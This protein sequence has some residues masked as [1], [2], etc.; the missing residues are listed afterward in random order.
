MPREARAAADRI[1]LEPKALYVV[2]TPIGNLGDVTF[3]AAATLASVDV[4]CAEDT[5]HTRVLLDHLGID[6]PLVSLHEH[7]EAR[8]IARVLARLAGGETIALV[9]D[10]G[11]PL[12]SDPGERLVR[13]VWDAGYRVI[14]VPGA[15]ALTAALSAAGLETTPF[16][17][18]G[19]LPRTGRTHAALLAQLSVMSHTSVLY[20][21]PAR[22]ARTLAELVE[23]GCGA[24]E[25]AVAREVTKRFEE[26]R[27]GTVSSL[28]TYYASSA[29]R[30]E[31]VVMVAGRTEEPVD[32]MRLREEVRS[33]RQNG[34]PARDITRA[35][36]QDH[37]V[38]RNLAYRLAHDE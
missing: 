19:F 33:M 6:T 29:P 28:A 9:S 2:S 8:S 35:L 10:A 15:S 25:A 3:R 26:F 38:P 27:R 23:L 18:F 17:F 16:T 20:E 1:Q 37:A 36:I 22:L 4:V 7:N 30:G 11:T 13:A 21:S 32:E 31:V 5:R 34:V 12:I 24:R 14:P